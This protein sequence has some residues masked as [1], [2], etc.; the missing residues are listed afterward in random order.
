[1]KKRIVGGMSKDFSVSREDQAANETR[2]DIK[3]DI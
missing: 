1:M 3:D 2:L